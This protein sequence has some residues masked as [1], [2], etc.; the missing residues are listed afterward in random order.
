[1]KLA[2]EFYA[3][4]EKAA[5]DMAEVV[6]GARGLAAGAIKGVRAAGG[7]VAGK[8]LDMATRPGGSAIGAAAGKGLNAVGNF[9]RR[10]PK[11]TM[12]LGAAGTAVA[13]KKATD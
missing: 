7:A 6:K 1:M 11:A 5:V 2:P 4:F 8:G 10:N 13:A 9:A 3:G 12:A